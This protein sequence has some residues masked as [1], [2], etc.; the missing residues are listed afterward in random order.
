MGN[1][2]KRRQIKAAKLKRL[3]ELQIPP[4][5]PKPEPAV[6][7]VVEEKPKPEP[8]V[9]PVVEEKPKPKPRKTT[10]RKRKTSAKPKIEE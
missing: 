9:A 3:Q 5:E 7:P 4:I 8:A 2:R 10:T 6:A 1:P